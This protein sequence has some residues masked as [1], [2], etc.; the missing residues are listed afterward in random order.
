M[1]VMPVPCS[2]VP[3]N[4][5]FG[6]VGRLDSAVASRIGADE[7]KGTLTGVPGFPHLRPTHRGVRR[8]AR[9]GATRGRTREQGAGAGHA[10]PAVSR[11]RPAALP[12][13]RLAAYR[14]AAGT[15]V[16]LS[17]VR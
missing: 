14:P 4:S 12:G 13:Q 17:P 11:P 3:G 16:A 2:V 9:T 6:R 15:A 10:A 8:R 1:S 7:Q 5:P